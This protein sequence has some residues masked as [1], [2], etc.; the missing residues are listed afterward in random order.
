MQSFK[1][2]LFLIYFFFYYSYK[3]IYILFLLLEIFSCLV[4]RFDRFAAFLAALP[5]VHLLGCTMGRMRYANRLK[6]LK[7][8]ACGKLKIHKIATSN[9]I[10]QTTKPP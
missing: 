1:Y 5:S 6:I 8:A 4:I 7:A 10:E 2:Y 3:C 9:V